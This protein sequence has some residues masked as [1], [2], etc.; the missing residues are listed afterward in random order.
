MLINEFPDIDEFRNLAE[1]ANVIPVCMEMLADTETPVSLLR[2]F[3]KNN[4]SVFLFESVE[5]GERWGRYSFLGVSARTHIRIFPQFV[6]VCE[7]GSRRQIAH[8]GDPFA[9]L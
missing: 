1:Q 8:N 6:E 7:N 2:K 3:Y 5:G 9:V 4:T